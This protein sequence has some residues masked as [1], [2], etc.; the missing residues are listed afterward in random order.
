MTTAPAGDSEASS[1]PERLPRFREV[2]PSLR[3]AFFRFIG[4]GVLPIICFYLGFRLAGP[5]P[6]ILA[7][8]VASL[9]ALAVQAWRLRRLDPVGVLPMAVILVQGS[10]AGL[11][12]STE[13]YLAAPAVEAVIWGVVLIG[14]VIARRPLVPL[15]AR[16]LGVV[17]RSLTE[18]AGLHRALG[19]LTFAWGIAALAK[20][21]IRIWLLVTLPLEAFLIAITVA[22]AVINLAMLAI[23]VWLPFRVLRQPP[24]NTA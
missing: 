18:S 22:I 17:P 19:I 1:E 23:S 11:A 5:V 21:A 14:S 13:I 9:L 12:G 8:M 7:G 10:I 15:I 16:E 20:A 4:A 6:G 2:W 3:R 24:G